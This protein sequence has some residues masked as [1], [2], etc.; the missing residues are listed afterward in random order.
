MLPAGHASAE[1]DRLTVECTALAALPIPS[2]AHLDGLMQ[3]GWKVV[4]AVGKAESKRS[5]LTCDVSRSDTHARGPVRPVATAQKLK[6]DKSPMNVLYREG[7]RGHSVQ[8]IDCSSVCRGIALHVC[9][10]W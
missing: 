5:L 10:I 1:A 3:D 8:V 2:S 7:G 6:L 9:P 4:G